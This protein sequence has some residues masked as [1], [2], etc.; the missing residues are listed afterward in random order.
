MRRVSTRKG[1]RDGRRD[2]GSEEGAEG[3]AA[4][5]GGRF[6]LM[7]I[8]DITNTALVLVFSNRKIDFF[9]SWKNTDSNP[10]PTAFKSCTLTLSYQDHL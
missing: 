5:M 2:G 10:L 8:C 9:R 7:N 4:E 3:G 1:G 6:R